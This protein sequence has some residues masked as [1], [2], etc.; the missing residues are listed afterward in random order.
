MS[1]F[2]EIRDAVFSF[3]T[4][5]VWTFLHPV[6]TLLLHDGSAILISAAE[7]AVTAG[8]A[9]NGQEAM[10]IALK[11]F[12]VEVV[13]KGVPFIESQARSLIELALQKAKAA[14]DVPAPL[15]PETPALANAVS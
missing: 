5:P 2:T 14:V 10:A 12:E 7:N 3:F 9:A 11:T 1:K 4:G 15:T 8:F 13:A 6:I